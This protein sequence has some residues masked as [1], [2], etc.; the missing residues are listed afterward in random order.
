M[1]LVSGRRI[2]RAAVHPAGGGSPPACRSRGGRRSFHRHA[3]ACRVAGRQAGQ[4]DHPA[5]GSEMDSTGDLRGATE[6]AAASAPAEPVV[7]VRDLVMPYARREAVAALI[8]RFGTARSS[9]SWARTARA[10]PRRSRSSKAS[11]A[12]DG[13]VRVLGVDP[14]RP[15][16]RG[17]TGWASSCRSPSPSP[18]SPCVSAWSCTRATTGRPAT[19]DDTIAL[20]GLRQ[21]GRARRPAVRRPTA[22]AGCRARADRRPRPRLPRRAHHGLRSVRAPGRLGGHRRA[23]RTRQDDLSHHPLHGR[24]RTSGRP[25]RGP[26]RPGASSPRAPRR[27]WAAATT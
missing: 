19:I 8:S 2:S 11:A 10:R 23:T 20:V 13:E 25:H 14:P 6:P 9:P 17:G 24:S 22:P 16:R 4:P 7:S 27:P 5:Q 21:G 15:A 26:R 3:G 12:T 18:A 1:S